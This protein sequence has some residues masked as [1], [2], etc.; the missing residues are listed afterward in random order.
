MNPKAR[1]FLNNLVPG[2]GLISAETG[3][4]SPLKPGSYLRWE[5]TISK[6]Q[7][8]TYKATDETLEI[9]EENSEKLQWI[10]DKNELFLNDIINCVFLFHTSCKVVGRLILSP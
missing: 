5:C 1:H 7:S 10:N 4:L 8:L 9:R 2:R 3:V 6:T